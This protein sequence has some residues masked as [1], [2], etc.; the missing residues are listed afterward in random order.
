MKV[1]SSRSEHI[2][3]AR[4]IVSSQIGMLLKRRDTRHVELTQLFPHYRVV[5]YGSAVMDVD[6]Y[7]A[8]RQRG[9]A[10]KYNADSNH[11]RKRFTTAHELGHLMLSISRNEDA[12]ESQ[13]AKEGYQTEEEALVDMI[14]AEILMP[15]DEVVPF[16]KGRTVDWGFVRDLAEYFQVSL[17]A[18][19]RRLLN[20]QDMSGIWIRSSDDSSARCV[21]WGSPSIVECVGESD[22]IW[23]LACSAVVRPGVLNV[24]HRCLGR[25]IGVPCR[26]EVMESKKLGDCQW[27]IGWIS[28]SD[29]DYY[30]P[31][32]A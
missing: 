12:Q 17:T 18:A 5:E 23:R 14:A 10:I 15:T 3:E 7:L 8:I 2:D 21:A 6:G 28:D 22:D 1:R 4:R 25:V 30:Y 13:R 31:D 26:T 20:L 11:R 19:I 29:A 9:F 27:T 24:L 16:V 32:A